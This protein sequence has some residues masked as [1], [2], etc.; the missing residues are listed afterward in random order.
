MRFPTRRADLRLCPQC[1]GLPI[2]F[3]P[4]RVGTVRPRPARSGT[5]R[6]TPEFAWPGCHNHEHPCGVHAPLARPAGA[7]ARGSRDGP[8]ISRSHDSTVGRTRAPGCSVSGLVWSPG[9]LLSR[10]Y[11]RPRRKALRRHSL[12]VFPPLSEFRPQVP[13]STD[14]TDAPGRS[15]RAQ[16][17]PDAEQDISDGGLNGRGNLSHSSGSLRRAGTVAPTAFCISLYGSAGRRPCPGHGSRSRARIGL[18]WQ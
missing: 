16:E 14:R 17:Q 5:T 6:S 12:V 1:R 2:G 15:W 3:G 10:R 8:V 13:A 4:A 11:R 9:L 7:R 18:P